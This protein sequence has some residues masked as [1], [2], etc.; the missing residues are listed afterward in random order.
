MKN[1]VNKKSSSLKKLIPAAGMLAVSAMMLATSTYAWFS[2]STKVTA[3]G[4]EMKATASKNL[5]ITKTSADASD[6]GASVDMQ[7][8][9]TSL[10][11][12]STVGGD[13]A[14]PT[15]YMIQNPGN[16]MS[17][18]N[19]ARAGD[20]KFTTASAGTHF[21]KTSVWIKCVGEN[22]EDLKATITASEGGE[23]ALDPAIRV[24]IVDATSGKTFIYS[25]I[26]GAEYLTSGQAINGVDSSSFATLG[27]ITSPATSGSTVIRA[28][29][30]KDTAYK[31]DI[32]AWYEGE[33]KSCKASNTL[34]M[35]TYKFSIDFAVA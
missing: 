17:Q 9:K 14:S 31:Y 11:P 34:D 30:A 8:S 19:A 22:T 18:D 13:T 26:D 25:P 32:Y 2:M 10:V 1:N 35:A 4:M 12:V 27:A 23:K 3:T 5:L 20:T 33:D 21:V 29:L 24:M 6:Y 7:I 16:G 15:F 28:E